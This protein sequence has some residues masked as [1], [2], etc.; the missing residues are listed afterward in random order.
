VT[1]GR[2]KEEV[3]GLEAETVGVPGELAVAEAA[4]TEAQRLRSELLDELTG[5]RLFAADVRTSCLRRAERLMRILDQVAEGHVR[6]ALL[7]LR[8]SA[9]L[10][11]EAAEGLI[12]D[13]ADDLGALVARIDDQSTGGNE[14]SA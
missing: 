9:L 6:G 12:G 2:L 13:L 11:A 8:R 5:A 1:I 14:G 3:A 10:V 7:T 4:M